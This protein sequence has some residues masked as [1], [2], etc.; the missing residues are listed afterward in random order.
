MV[1][2]PDKGPSYMVGTPDEG[3]GYMVG[4]PEFMAFYLNILMFGISSISI[5]YRTKFLELVPDAQKCTECVLSQD[6][7]TWTMIYLNK[8]SERFDL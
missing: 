6:I 7:I 3:P 2:I 4:N 8:T 5:K 1:G